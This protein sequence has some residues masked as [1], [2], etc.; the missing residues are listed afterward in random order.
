MQPV[1]SKSLF[2]FICEKMDKLDKKEIT[3]EEAN[4]QSNLAR[5]AINLLNYELDRAAT[6][7]K[8]AQAA[9]DLGVN[10]RLREIESKGFDDTTNQ[11]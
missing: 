2:A 1:N 6:E 10:I 7:I 11:R 3:V 9:K 8:T 4:S 5:Q